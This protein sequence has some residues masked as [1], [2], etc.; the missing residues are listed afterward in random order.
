MKFSGSLLENKDIATRI[1][2]NSVSKTKS[3]LKDIFGLNFEGSDPMIKAVTEEVESFKFDVVFTLNEREITADF[4]Y[5]VEDLA[6]DIVTEILTISES[7]SERIKMADIR[8]DTKDGKQLYWKYVNG[9]QDYLESKFEL[10]F[11]PL[12]PE[13]KDSNIISINPDEDNLSWICAFNQEHQEGRYEATF[14][15]T[16]GKD[17]YMLLTQRKKHMI[18]LD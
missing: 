16:P 17:Q 7:T 12:D 1:F 11:T 14:Q 3:I 9:L 15:L 5:E 13:E 10:N 4:K 18:Y 8:A 6:G 2:S